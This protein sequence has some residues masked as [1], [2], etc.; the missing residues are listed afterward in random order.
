MRSRYFLVIMIIVFL[1]NNLYSNNDLKSEFNFKELKS[2]P[3]LPNVRYITENLEERK[4]SYS[5][6]KKT[7]IH[8]WATW[9][10][11][12]TK[13]LPSLEKYLKKN[14]K[15]I[16][17]IMI[18]VDFKEHSYVKNFLNRKSLKYIKS[19]MAKDKSILK[20]FKIRGLPTTLIVDRKGKVSHIAQGE[21]NWN[22]EK[23]NNIITQ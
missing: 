5:K 14:H 17:F 23:L 12:C 2:K 3:Y 9:C 15:K 10:G 16:N 4:L 7:I 11:I 18:N 19:S 13:E 8:F 20:A 6:E 21:V 22:S 1:N